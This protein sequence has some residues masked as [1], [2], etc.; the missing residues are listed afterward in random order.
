[1]GIVPENEHLLGLEG[2][3]IVRRVG[4]GAEKFK[5]GD[6]VAVLRNGTFANRIQVPIERTHILPDS[7][8]FEDASTIPLVYLTSIYSLFNTANLK[9]GQSV[10]IHSA[11]GGVGI[12][13]IQLAQYV[14]AEIYVTVSTEEKRKFLEESFGIKPERMFSSRS[15]DFASEIMQAT[16]GAGIDVIINSLI[17]ELL[18][19]SWRIC[20]DGGCMVEI[21]KKD[22]VDRNHLS[23]EPFDRNC[24]FRAVDFSHKQITDTLIAE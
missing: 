21:G 6:R 3:G 10:L 24:S 17:G 8:S 4:K 1:M 5:V 19:E 7:L 18:D 23:M 20:A 9:R 12:A 13:C 11:A 2:A 16:N 15:T 14:G 22:I